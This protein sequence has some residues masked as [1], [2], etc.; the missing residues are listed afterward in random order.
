[1]NSEKRFL[2]PSQ[3]AER[4]GISRATVYRWSTKSTTFPRP[5][6][7]GSATFFSVA[8]LE[9]WELNCLQENPR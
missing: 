5:L 1:M 2:R 4:Y 6:R 8:E 3:V 9:V 7:F